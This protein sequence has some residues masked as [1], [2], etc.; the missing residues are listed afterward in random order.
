MTQNLGV[1]YDHPEGE[2][3]TIAPMPAGWQLPTEDPVTG[4]TVLGTLVAPL[5]ATPE[6]IAAAFIRE[7]DNQL[8]YE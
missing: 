2:Q 5:D 6:E 1:T 7:A 4:G 8:T 3:V